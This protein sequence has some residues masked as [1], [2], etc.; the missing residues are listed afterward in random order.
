MRQTTTILSGVM[1]A[2]ALTLVVSACARRTEKVVTATPTQADVRESKAPTSSTVGPTSD[3]AMAWAIETRLASEGI[4]KDG[5]VH[6]DN[7]HGTVYLKGSVDTPE[8]NR[9]AGE[10]AAAVPG[11][12]TVVNQLRV[13]PPGAMS[14]AG[15]CSL[16]NRNAAMRTETIFGPIQVRVFDDVASPLHH[17]RNAKPLTA[18]EEIRA[19]EQQ[20]GR[21]LTEA[22]IRSLEADRMQASTGAAAMR[23]LTQAE[24]R[25]LEAKKGRAL[26]E[27]EIYD[28]EQ[29]PPKEAD[30]RS[31]TESRAPASGDPGLALTEQD[32]LTTDQRGRLYGD[33]ARVADRRGNLLWS[34][35]LKP[36]ESV[37]ISNGDLPIRYD[38]RFAMD[39]RFHDEQG[40][41]CHDNAIIIGQ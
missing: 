13:G 3:R 19:L 40:A 12:I 39:D 41:T 8:K 18:A 15:R 28:L 16:V 26:T 14:D 32:R 29:R 7:D 10:L 35:W 9:R 21:P 25:D 36:N 20:K 37:K 1:L 38:Y 2:L 34:G 30:T 17:R 27:A 5:N 6:V 33:D 24:I 23:T 4:T 11:V 22:E 31:L